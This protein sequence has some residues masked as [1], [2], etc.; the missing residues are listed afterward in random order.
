MPGGAAVTAP[1]SGYAPV[2]GIQ[3][4]YEL[5][6]S[7]E[8][9]VVLHGGL[10]S[11]A[12]YGATIDA[13]AQHRQVI[14]VDL[15]GHG[16]TG[17]VD[18]R[19]LSFEDMADDI[20]ALS[21]HLGFAQTDVMGY[22][23]GAGVAAQTAIRHRARVRRVVFVSGTF[24]RDGLFPEGLAALEQLG[25]HL[26]EFMKP[27]P[28]YQHYAKVAPRPE[29]FG[30]LIGEIGALARRERDWMSALPTFPPTLLVYGD[31]DIVRPQHI[32]EIY[33]GLGGGQRDPGWDGSAG[34]S[35]SQLAI[36]PGVSHY[37]IADHP[38]LAATVERFLAGK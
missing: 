5:H 2:N 20:G 34:R 30:K 29:D 27:A 12:T 26:A 31:A 22:S 6:G 3:L 33:A 21:A 38:L 1:T 15:Y 32:V 28:A 36:L 13:L 23:F 11:I 24:R 35:A 17:F 25:P 14:A 37:V 10:G 19:G 16:H 18:G 4:Y 9:L 8:P 7:G